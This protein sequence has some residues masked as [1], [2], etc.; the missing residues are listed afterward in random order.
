MSENG[1]QAGGHRKMTREAAKDL[2]GLMLVLA[3]I[4]GA[5]LMFRKQ[6]RDPA[7]EAE[8]D[9]Y[10]QKIAPGHRDPRKNVTR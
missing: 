8:R 1:T 9:W 10:Y 6:F 2:I 5:M 3:L 4:V 7:G